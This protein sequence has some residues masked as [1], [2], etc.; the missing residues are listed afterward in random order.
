MLDLRERLDQSADR[1]NHYADTAA[2]IVVDCAI[3]APTGPRVVVKDCIDIAGLPTRAG[4]PALAARAPAHQHA[5]VV[6]QLIDAGCLIVGKANMHELAYGVT[7]INAWTGTP[8][9]PTFPAL[10]PGGSSSGSAAAVAAGLCDFAIGTDT[11][12][13]IRMPAACCGI[14]GLKPTFGRLSRAG[15]TP[16]ESTLDCV[17]PLASSAVGL[18]AAMRPLDPR[19]RALPAPHSLR[20]CWLESDADP[21]VD[22]TVSAFLA[23]AVGSTPKIKVSHFADAHSAGLAIIGHEA[24]RAVGMLFEQGGVGADIATRLAA[25]GVIDDQ[26]VAEARDVGRQFAD[27]LDAVFDQYDVIA[28]PT[29]PNLPPTLA[30]AQ[31]L[32]AVVPLTSLCRPFNVSGHPA[33]AMPAGLLEGRPVSLQLVARRGEDEQ[34]LALAEHIDRHTHDAAPTAQLLRTSATE[35]EPCLQPQL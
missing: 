12:G 29:L 2:M 18:T 5:A 21:A 11:G 19:F 8:V 4:S 14:Y 28:L 32:M 22:S 7:G 16:A 23:K 25:A 27:C 26:A 35:I 33:L 31:D 3:G 6:Q 1:A 20:I 10:I 9:N 34:L 17:G 30:E 15:L 13:S 24:S